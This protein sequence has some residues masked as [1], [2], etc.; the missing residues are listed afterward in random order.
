MPHR[1]I[2]PA[3]VVMTEVDRD[4]AEAESF[5][6]PDAIELLGDSQDSENLP[7]QNPPSVGSPQVY[8]LTNSGPSSGVKE[9]PISLD[10]DEPMTMSV[11]NGSVME[12]LPYPAAGGMEEDDLLGTP[13]RP[14]AM[15]AAIG[16]PSVLAAPLPVISPLSRLAEEGEASQKDRE[17]FIRG[18][19]TSMEKFKVRKAKGAGKSQSPV[20]GQGDAPEFEVYLHFDDGSTVYKML[21]VHPAL[22]EAQIGCSAR[23]YQDALEKLDAKGAAE[24]KRA[25]QMKFAAFRGIYRCEWKKSRKKKKSGGVGTP[26]LLELEAME[27]VTDNTAI[28]RALT[29]AGMKRGPV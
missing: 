15:N 4:D 17:V 10:K 7:A 29:R 23:A 13:P 3:P 27:E 26:E 11:E 28:V 18:H 20:K 12:V 25:T 14:D 21:R 22:C 6:Y 19:G 5:L 24:Y 1:A 2:K 9:S 16:A 8:D